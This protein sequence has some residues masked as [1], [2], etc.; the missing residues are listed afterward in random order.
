MRRKALVAAVTG[1]IGCSA[2]APLA[3][4]NYPV[5]SIRF[6]IPFPP[7]GGTDLF[8]RLLGQKISEAWGHQ[9]IIDSRP[10]AQG[11]LGTAQ[12]ARAA[13]DGYTL[14]LA[15]TGP[16]TIN[17]FIY[18]NVGYDPI[19]DFNAVSLGTEQPYLAVVHPSV[20]ARTLKELATLART[21]PGKMSFASSSSIAQL[22]GELFKLVTHSDILHIPYKGAGGAAFD[23]LAGNVDLMFSTP[24]A[25]M[26]H[27]VAGKL[28]ALAITSTS[29][30]PNLPD[31][32]TSK[33]AGFP[34]FEVTG[35][36]GIAVPAAT[37]RDV[38]L[39][40]NA[41]IS[42]I[43]ALPDVKERLDSGGLSASPSSPEQFE[44]LIKRDYDRWGKVVKTIGMSAN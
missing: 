2:A 13:P 1:F 21:Q 41:E 31:V 19:K 16:F 37:P 7:G 3:A 27:V 6:I 20:P 30:N 9:V 25:S 18:K 5:K 23:L 12:A 43:L 42:R 4:Q 10:G 17:P 11:S 34:E 44:A 8:G 24:T 15:Q 40:L 26:P 39:R 32:P 33:E 38:I 28:R 36:Y 22:V 14:L 29:R 35:W